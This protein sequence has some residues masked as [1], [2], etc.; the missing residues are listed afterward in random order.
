MSN[1]K[2]TAKGKRADK[3]KEQTTCKRKSITLFRLLQ[4]RQTG[5]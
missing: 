4:R 2:N 1:K 3:V 5:I